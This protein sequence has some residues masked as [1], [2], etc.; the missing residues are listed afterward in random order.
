MGVNQRGVFAIEMSFVLFFIAALLIFTGDIA[1]KLFNRIALDRVS[2]SLV[3]IVKERSRFYDKRFELNKRDI[4]DIQM[5]ASRLLGGHRSFGL[6]VQ[7]LNNGV[8]QTFDGGAGAGCNVPALSAALVPEN[9]AGTAFPL[10]QVTLCY[11]IDNWF[12]K[13]L[14]SKTKSHLQSTSVIV[15]R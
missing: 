4:D 2:Y 10:Y 3:N 12:D 1:F 15:G 13:F 14:G 9:I 7:S 11:D 5:L 8:N 6:R